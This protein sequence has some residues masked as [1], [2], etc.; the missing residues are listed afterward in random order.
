MRYRVLCALVLGLALPDLAGC[1]SSEEP[2]D[3]RAD[4]AEPA[5]RIAV[6]TPGGSWPRWKFELLEPDDE[7]TTTRPSTRRRPPAVTAQPALPPAP[8]ITNN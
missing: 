8:R 2:A 6:D 5:I 4:D 1:S 7:V 3:A